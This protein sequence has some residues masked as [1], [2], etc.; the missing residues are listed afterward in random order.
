MRNNSPYYS[1]T[2]KEINFMGENESHAINNSIWEENAE[3]PHFEALEE[4]KNT[5]V[6]IIGGGIAGILC[7][8]MLKNAGVDC[9]LAEARRICSGITQ[10][11]TAKITLGHS[12]LYDKLIRRFGEERARLYLEAQQ[13]ACWKY[14]ELCKNI[15]CD[16][17]AKD[18]YVYSMNSHKKI[19]QEVDALNRLGVGAEFSA[20]L[21]LPLTVAG[22]VCVKNQAQF[23]PLKFAFFFFHSEFL[24]RK[25]THQARHTSHPFHSRRSDRQRAR[26]TEPFL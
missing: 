9:I 8:Y 2:Q 19:E 1:Y 21:P 16:Y 15:P 22:A 23:N 12:L 17:E 24:Y 3:R 10:N 7:A 14:A 6:L 13:K 25:E 11:T 18:S 20:K 5:D 26:R 4:S